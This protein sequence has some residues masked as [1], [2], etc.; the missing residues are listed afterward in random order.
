MKGMS[1]SAWRTLPIFC[2]LAV[3]TSP[4]SEIRQRT[5]EVVS[6]KPILP[7]STPTRATRIIGNSVRANTSVALLL[8]T[9]YGLDGFQVAKLP[10]WAETEFYDIAGTA[11]SKWG[12][13]PEEYKLLC[14][15]LLED[16]FQ[17][18]THFETKD[19]DV[20]TLVPAKGGAKLKPANA[21]GEYS[22]KMAR[23]G[24]WQVTKEDMMHLA[25][26][27]SRELGEIVLDETGLTGRF[28]FTLKWSPEK[29]ALAANDS[30]ISE[31]PSIFMAVQQQLGLRLARRRQPMTILVIDHVER[32]SAN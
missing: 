11:D 24:F 3:G 19:F 8:H 7:G 6:I 31:D 1:L 14:R 12:I 32:P 5:F 16:R 26:S 21:G 2:A 22:F 29:A 9:A 30:G 28:D 23:P 10:G 13:T 17:L 4:A 15:K 25:R 18:K 27:L 20:Y